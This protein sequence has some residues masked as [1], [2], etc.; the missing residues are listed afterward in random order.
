MKLKFS[1]EVKEIFTKL[2]RAKF[3]AYIVGGCVRDLLLGRE[4]KDWDF[5]TDALP[6]Q[7]VKL[8]P[9]SFYDNKFGTVGVKIKNGRQE[10]NVFEITTFRSESGYSDHRHPDKIV[11][12]KTLEEDLQR[13]DFT[14]NAMASDGTKIIDLYDGQK[15]LKNKIIK[16]VGDPDLRFKEDSLR[17]MRAVRFAT[18]LKYLI[19]VKTFSAIKENSFLLA[20]ISHERIRDELLKIIE[21]DYPADGIILLRNAGLI[22]IILPELEK[23][24]GVEQKSPERH[25]IY[26]VGTHSIM[27]LKHC[28]SRNPIVRFATLLHDIGKP[29]TAGKTPE[30][31]ITFY[32]HEII[33][34]SIVRNIADRLHFSKKDRDLL[35]KLVRYHQFTVDERQTDTALR[36]FLRN[37]GKENLEDMLALRTGDRLGGGARETSWRLELYKKR[38]VEVQ[39][40]PFTVADLK[41]SG[42]AVMKIYGIGP[43]PLV[44]AVLKML[45]DDVVK[46]ILKNEKEV[47]LKRINDLKKESKITS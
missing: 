6:S 9:D 22:N 12:G 40:Q 8:F 43:G 26:D 31:V 24:F 27:A 18:Y 44:G 13:R 21:S 32:N 17:M 2:K 46:G 1:E 34:A 3:Q 28:P 15:D 10:T 45:F 14:I 42:H 7:I 41:V 25:H 36:R 5:T 19:D 33:G 38:L 20:K 29:V 16:A 47:L 30:G 11:W 37:V 23:C 39:K 35:V 4:T